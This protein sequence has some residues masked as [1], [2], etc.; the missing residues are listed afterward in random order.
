[1][2]PS[3]WQQPY[4]GAPPPKGLP[5]FIRALYPPSAKNKGKT[6]STNGPDVEAVKR[7]NSR[8]GRWPWQN[9]DQEYSD[10]FAL[11]NPSSIVANSGMAG[12]QRQQGIEDTGWMGEKTYNAL[13][14][15]T[16]PVGLPHAG[17]HA[18]DQTAI[19]LLC[20]A[21][22]IYKEKPGKLT[23]KAIPSPN[24]SGRGGASVRLIVLHTAEGALTIEALGNYFANPGVDASSHVGVDD[25]AGVIGEY[26]QRASKAW[27]QAN[28]NPVAVSAELCAFANWS[29]AEWNQHPQML[30]NT[31]RWIAEEAAALQI[32]IVKLS[33]SQAQGSGRGVCQ[34]VDLGSWGGGHYDCGGSFPID[35]VLD[36][37]K[38][39]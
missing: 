32:P 4:P 19:D 2:S 37:A 30:E 26:V 15:A 33:P 21:A 11:G 17:D 8:L 23:R 6:P 31:A 18:F 3:W 24:Y 20:E 39:L 14:Y 35:S 12:F 13:A 1:M 9:F 27:T 25:K 36:R 7:A 34:H 28:A 10:R 5:S 29:A 16:I 38:T 22:D